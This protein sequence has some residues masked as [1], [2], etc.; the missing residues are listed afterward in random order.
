MKW[1]EA[2]VT[3][4]PAVASDH[5]PL[6]MQ[7]C[8]S[9]RGNPRRRPFRFEAAWLLHEGFKELLQHSWNSTLTTPEALNGLRVRL[10]RW[11]REVFGDINKRKELLVNEIKSVQDLLDVSQSDE[12]LHK[13]EE[14]IKELDVV[15]EQ[16]EIVWFQ[17]S[18]EKWISEGDRNTKY[19]HT[20][21]IIRR[22]KNRIEMLKN[23]DG[24]WISDP[25]ELEDLAVAYYTRLYSMDDIDPDVEKLPHE[26]FAVLTE[27]EITRL[28]RP[29]SGV[30]VEESIRSMGKL[31]APGPDGYQPIFYQQ[32]WDVVGESVTRFVLEFFETGTL[33]EGTNDALVVLIPKV[34]KPETIM[35]F[36]PISLCNVLF[37]TIT[38]AMMRRLKSVMPK[39]IGPAQS[40]FIPGRLSTDNII[41]VQEAVHSMRRKKDARVGCF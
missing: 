21:T 20:S 2:T 8:P 24:V 11:N 6:Y 23:N 5:A 10:K 13:E 38:K 26:G 30:E 7:L 25:K 12:L 1:Q 33:P 41:V 18:R 22:R 32:C 15:M 39:L 40:S 28:M 34:A 35:Q 17:K 14:L 29:F 16:E 4:L 31:K 3:H 19:F 37:K 36:R 27:G 9:N